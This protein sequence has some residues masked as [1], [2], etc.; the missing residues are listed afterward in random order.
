[1]HK[2]SW[3]SADNVLIVNAKTCGINKDGKEQYLV[4]PTT[5]IRSV[6]EI[7]DN[8]AECCDAIMQGNFTRDEIFYHE[9]A[10]MIDKDVFVPKYYD[11]ETLTG[12]E[13][14]VASNKDLT[15][16]SLGELKDRGDIKIFGGHGSPSSDQRLGSIPYI[17]VSDLRAGHVNINPTNMV[18]LDLAKKFWGSSNSG[19]QPY[20]LIS[21][22]RASKNIGEFCVL[23]PGQEKAVFTKEVIIVRA[24][25]EE[26]FDQFYLL[27]ALS[28]NEVRAQW[29]RIV[30][31]QTNREDVGKRML[32]IQIPVPVDRASA[33]SYSYP[34]KKYYSS[35]EDSRKQFITSL[36]ES[37][38]N[39]H[40]HLGE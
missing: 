14:L 20:D 16:M 15:L 30:F 28:L 36:T 26:L 24:V 35:L 7:D 18:P 39:H 29:E 4:N 17:K 19:L 13:K 22:E 11:H 23:M 10:D 31:M 8:L 25:N 40:I 27:W 3:F 12:V 37:E 33:D 6:S 2:P 5:G 32:E 21:P 9:Y 34:F 38:F 1:M